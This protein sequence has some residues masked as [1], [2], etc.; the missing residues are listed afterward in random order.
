MVY[1]NNYTKYILK[2]LSYILFLFFVRTFSGKKLYEMVITKLCSCMLLY[3]YMFIPYTVKEC[4]FTKEGGG[5]ENVI[6][7]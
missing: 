2:V 5:G 3:R 4:C 1:L 7:M 6:S